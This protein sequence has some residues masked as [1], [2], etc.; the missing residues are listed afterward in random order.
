MMMDEGERPREPAITEA[1][2][3]GSTP[4]GGDGERPGAGPAEA[5]GPQ[6]KPVTPGD[7]TSDSPGGG[8]KATGSGRR[9]QRKNRSFWRELPI[10]IAVAL[11][12]ALV[13]KTYA[14]QAYFIPSSSMENTLDI[15]D[16]VLVNKI[17]Y[18]TRSIHRGD[19][20]V[21]NGQGSWDL[22]SAQPQPSALSRFFRGIVG[23]F[24]AAPG[25]HDYIKRV[26]GIPGDHVACCDP[27]G[28]LTVN[29]VPLNE[30]TYL[31]AGDSPSTV[32]FTF[33]VPPNRLWVMGDHRSVSYDS[34]GH[35]GDPGG[36]SIPEN[37]V[38]GRAF[39][40][41]WPVSRWRILPIP[42]TFQ[43]PKLTGAQAPASG[44]PAG[45]A[46]LSAPVRPAAPVL[47]LTL[48]F[49]GAVPLTWLQRRLR[50]GSSRRGAGCS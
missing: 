31:F 49:A 6:A 30:P 3:A 44:G 36:G 27:Q 43:Q 14:V 39:V 28:R 35:M 20:V 21:F 10:L 47:P 18:D 50:K 17:V 19:I 9:Q 8:R 25:E 12:L 42:S 48:G 32:R 45:Q 37:E 11:V 7:G 46:A 4:Q 41:I 29:G 33:T 5:S 2:D 38:V 24:G 1:R 34:R 26:I 15:G 23:L 13:I 22:G 40:I 16:K